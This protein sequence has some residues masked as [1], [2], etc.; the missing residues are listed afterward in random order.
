MLQAQQKVE[1]PAPLTVT[2]LL[3]SEWRN[4]WLGPKV[5]QEFGMTQMC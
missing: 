5:L 4:V 1:F 2:L 3:K